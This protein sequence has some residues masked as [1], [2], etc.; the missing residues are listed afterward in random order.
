MKTIILHIIALLMFGAVH[1]QT[2]Q[3]ETKFIKGK[4]YTLVQEIFNTPDDKRE[5]LVIM[6]GDSVV[7]R[8]TLFNT[9]VGCYYT[10]AELGYVLPNLDQDELTFY[11]IWVAADLEPVRLYTARKQ[12]YKVED[13]GQFTLSESKMAKYEYEDDIYS[14]PFVEPQ[15]SEDEKVANELAE[16]EYLEELYNAKY[17]SKGEETEQLFSEV[18]GHHIDKLENIQAVISK[19]YD[20][21]NE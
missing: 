20:E 15:L 21:E 9:Y 10:W 4:K 7:L 8:Y 16:R 18:L 3:S 1:S 12:V 13:N 5:N 2:T 17:V 19:W 14:D 11:S 6:S